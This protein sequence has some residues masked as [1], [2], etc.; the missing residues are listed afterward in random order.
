M[1]ALQN[2]DGEQLYKMPRYRIDSLLKDEAPR[3][4]SQIELAK[5][6]HGVITIA[7]T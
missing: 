2:A 1:A 6:I 3:M 5:N 7:K 4:A